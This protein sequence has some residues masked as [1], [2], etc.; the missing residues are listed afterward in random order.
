[1]VMRVLNMRYAI[2]NVLDVRRRSKRERI[3]KRRIRMSRKLLYNFTRRKV[4]TLKQE[5]NY[6]AEEI[7]FWPSTTLGYAR[8][9]LAIKFWELKISIWESLVSH[10]RMSTKG[11]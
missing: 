5:R 8:R 7:E 3:I 2:T 11:G 1:M 10:N 9:N 4:E 6:M